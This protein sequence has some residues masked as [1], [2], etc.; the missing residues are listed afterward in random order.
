MLHGGI[1]WIEQKLKTLGINQI[2]RISRFNFTYFHNDF[3]SYAHLYRIIIMLCGVP[4]FLTI[5]GDLESQIHDL[6]EVNEA[7]T[8]SL[9]RTEEKVRLLQE[10]NHDLRAKTG[11][12]FEVGFCLSFPQFYSLF[13]LSGYIK[14]YIRGIW[15]Q[16]E[17]LTSRVLVFVLVKISGFY[18]LSFNVQR[19]FNISQCYSILNTSKS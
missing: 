1:V 15:Q 14:Q 6:Q 12:N 9:S 18:F 16:I 8:S 2:E 5:E 3:I 11:N 10:E 4:L 19:G 17:A 13:K 7:T